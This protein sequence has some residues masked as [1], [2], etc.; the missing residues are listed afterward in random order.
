M[1]HAFNK[2]E[3]QICNNKKQKT[4]SAQEY[5]QFLCPPPVHLNQVLTSPKKQTC[6]LISSSE[7]MKQKTDTSIVSQLFFN[8]HIAS[9]VAD[10]TIA[11]G[12][13]LSLN[14]PAIAFYHLKKQCWF[15]YAFS[16]PCQKEKTMCLRKIASNAYVTIF[17]SI[18]HS[19][20]RED[21][22]KKEEDLEKDSLFDMLRYEYI[23]NCI[24]K[25]FQ[26]QLQSE[27]DK[28]Y[29]VGLEAYA[30]PRPEQAGY[31]YKLHELGGILKH[32]LKQTFNFKVQSIVCSSWKKKIVGHGNA[33]KWDI[34]QHVVNKIGIPLGFVP[35]VSNEF[36]KK[37][38][39]KN[40]GEIQ[41]PNPAQDIADAICLTLMTIIEDFSTSRT[42]VM[43]H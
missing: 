5:S 4:L 19:V 11:V 30:Y 40:T 29:I 37:C 35:L 21:Q 16:K 15:L 1:K 24:V 2:Q 32:R 12:I 38:A 31:N 8:K 39:K 41:V 26:E 18:K 36:L 17:A 3:V 7:K 42:G 43:S 13:D 34:Y 6:L 9:T 28:I 33:T 20:S 27:S 23:V 14:S 22:D 10:A 25:A